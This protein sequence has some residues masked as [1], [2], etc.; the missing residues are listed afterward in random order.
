MPYLSCA[1]INLHFT[2][3][4]QTCSRRVRPRGQRTDH[5]RAPP[6]KPEPPLRLPGLQVR[7]RSGRRRRRGQRG[8]QGLG[9]PAAA[10][11]FLAFAVPVQRRLQRQLEPRRY[12]SVLVR[13]HHCRLRRRGRRCSSCGRCFGRRRGRVRLLRHGED[14]DREGQAHAGREAGQARLRLPA[15]VVLQPARSRLVRGTALEG[16]RQHQPE[17]ARGGHWVQEEGRAAEKREA[18][19]DTRDGGSPGEFSLFRFKSRVLWAGKLLKK[20]PGCVALFPIFA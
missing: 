12:Q 6:L 17:Q 7:R 13:L 2:V 19:Q 15:A 3:L 10:R 4:P 18:T 1:S 11:Q 14:G 9:G 16:R 20:L 8:L 5:R